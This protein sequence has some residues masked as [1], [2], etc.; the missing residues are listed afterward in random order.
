MKNHNGMWLPEGDTFFANRG[1][2]EQYE[3]DT[4]QK[5]LNQKRVA[6]DIGAHVGYWSKRLVKDFD[7]VFAFEAEPEHVECL[8]QNVITDNFTVHPIALSNLTGI[9]KFSKSI[10]NSGMSHV[11]EIGESITCN[12]LDSFNLTD[13]DL[14]KIDVE[15]HELNVLE[16]AVKTITASRPTLFIEILNN[17]STSVRDGIFDLLKGLG[18][19]MVRNIAENYIFTFEA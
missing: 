11:S 15:G 4:V 9:V 16:G 14:I 6:V 10:D 3:Y 13:V 12:T 1:E 7:T 5:Y 17:T 19:K 18:Y 8:E 2:Y